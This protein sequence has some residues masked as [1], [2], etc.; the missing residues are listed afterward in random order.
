MENVI[1]IGLI[2]VMVL[3]GIRSAIKHFKGESSCCGGG[4]GEKVKKKKL[5]NVIARKTV[6]IEGMTCDH[7]KNRVERC[8]NEM[9]GVS[10]KVNLKKKEAV[11]VMEKEISEE[12]IRFVIEK[13]GY[14]VSK[15]S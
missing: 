9:D 8:L 11:V 15:I 7:C 5:K 1:I 10:A 12:Q 6:I 13:A 4:S 3:I 2:V 14:E